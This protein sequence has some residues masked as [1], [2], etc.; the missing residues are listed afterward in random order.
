MYESGLFWC[1]VIELRGLSGPFVLHVSRLTLVWG[2][3]RNNVDICRFFVRATVVMQ[4]LLLRNKYKKFATALWCFA[5]EAS[6]IANCKLRQQ[7]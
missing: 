3:F 5:K 1:D 6:S 7:H 4:V 2:V